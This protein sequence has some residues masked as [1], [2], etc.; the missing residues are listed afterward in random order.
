VI[1]GNYNTDKLNEE[2]VIGGIC[3]V[4]GAVLWEIVRRVI[5]K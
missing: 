2:I 5:F 4:G 1:L 3:V